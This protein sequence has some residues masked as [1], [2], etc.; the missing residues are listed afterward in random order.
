MLN[1]NLNYKK[2]IKKIVF[3]FYGKK[4]ICLQV[5]RISAPVI[6]GSGEPFF[7]GEL[8]GEHKLLL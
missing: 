2:Y 7:F 5:K 3:F 1:A 6:T 4:K 8:L